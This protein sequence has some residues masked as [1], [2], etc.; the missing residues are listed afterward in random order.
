VKE[1]IK[2]RV[3]A[4]YGTICTYHWQAVAIIKLEIGDWSVD[5]GHVDG[6]AVDVERT[7]YVQR[8][9]ERMSW[10]GCMY[11]HVLRMKM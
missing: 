11:V 7:S 4:R 1:G 2:T 3:R 10:S 6:C 5:V 8:Q 9:L